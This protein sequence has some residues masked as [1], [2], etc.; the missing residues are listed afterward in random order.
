MAESLSYPLED[1]KGM[2]KAHAEALRK[3]GVDNTESFL[4]QAKTPASRKALAEQTGISVDV[5]LE[6]ANRADLMRVSGIG[7]K[8]GDLL[9]IAG[10]DTVPEL[11]QRNPANLRKALEEANDQYNLVQALPAESVVANWVNQAK[12]LERRL[13]Y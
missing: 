2:T 8:Y 6:L 3:A 11:A 5:V 7:R 4:E 10:V 13:E 12:G 9:E 1:V